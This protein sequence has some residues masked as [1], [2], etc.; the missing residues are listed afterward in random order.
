[1]PVCSGY[2]VYLRRDPS[3]AGVRAVALPRRR[4]L[5]TDARLMPTGA[6]EPRAAQTRRLDRGEVQE[7]FALGSD[8]R[9]AVVSDARRPNAAAACERR[10]RVSA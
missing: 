4:R 7:V 8:R 3:A 5:V 10:A 1:M 6:I 2:R 9:V